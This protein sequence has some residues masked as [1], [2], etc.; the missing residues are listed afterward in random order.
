MQ[1]CDEKEQSEQGK[2]KSVPSGE[3]RSIRKCDGAESSAQGDKTPK[4][5]PDAARME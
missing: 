5:S 4:G 2:V 3:K 1:I